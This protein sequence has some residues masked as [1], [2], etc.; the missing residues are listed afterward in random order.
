MKSEV[1]IMTQVYCKKYRPYPT[2][3]TVKALIKY[4]YPKIVYYSCL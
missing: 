3:S 4:F 2:D 1:L